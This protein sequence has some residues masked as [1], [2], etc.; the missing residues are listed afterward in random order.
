MS[1]VDD[2]V[3]ALDSGSFDTV[4]DGLLGSMD[5]AGLDKLMAEMDGKAAGISDADK[6]HLFKNGIASIK[7]TVDSM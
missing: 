1:A 5:K 7:M 3:A 2:L 4:L 6:R